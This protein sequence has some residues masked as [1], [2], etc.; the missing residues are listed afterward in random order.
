MHHQRGVYRLANEL[1]KLDEWERASLI[2]L[3]DAKVADYIA[4]R[5]NAI[6]A[7]R[8]K[9]F[10]PLPGTLR[11]EVL[12]RAKG[13]CEACG[14]SNQE[15]AVQVDHIVPRAQGGSNDLS[16]LQALCDVCNAQKLDR[17]KTN[18]REAHIGYDQ[19][20]TSCPFCNV[21]RCRI[22][23]ENELVVAIVDA[24]PVTVGHR[25]IVPRRHV[26]DYFDLWQPE[27]NAVREL[28][29]RIVSL[30]KEEDPSIAGFNVGVNCGEAAGQT[31][32][33]CHIHLTPRRNGDVHDPR[34]G[35]RGVVPRKR[36]YEGLRPSSSTA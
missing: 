35:V 11:Y 17:D 30:L 3:C 32:S 31:I 18:F 9:N 24:F 26:T 15:R 8:F 34:G 20:E 10:D 29:L 2:A 22:I 28:E 27:L 14:V 21:D 33:H 5:Q 23:E 12:K 13:R 16:N 4:K 19:R 7:H 6:W 25:L 1:A 36:L